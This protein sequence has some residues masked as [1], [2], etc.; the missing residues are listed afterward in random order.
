MNIS[1]NDKISIARGIAW[2]AAIFSI[3]ICV[4]LIAN[5]I[6]YKSV[7]PL[8]SE[9]LNTLV[10]RLHVNPQDEALKEDIRALDLLIRKAYFTSQWQIKTGAYLLIF[11][12]LVFVL[13]VRY[14]NSLKSKL[15][16]LEGIEKNPFLD[17]QL[18]RKW[19]VYVGAGLILLALTSGY[20]SYNALDSYEP[21][22]MANT[23]TVD[24]PIIEE[25]TLVSTEVVQEDPIVSEEEIQEAEKTTTVEKT[26]S[27]DIS[28][29][30]K[31][32]PT[33]AEEQTKV[34]AETK[35]EKKEANQYKTDISIIAN[36]DELNENYPFFRGPQTNG[37]VHQTNIPTN[38]DGASGENILW[39]VKVPKHGYNSPIIWEDKLFLSGADNTVRQVYCFNKN[40]GEIL[41]QVDATGIP[42][43]PANAPETT[44]DT[45]LAA[46]TMATNGENVFAIFGTGDLVSLD[47]NGEKIWAKNLGVPDNHYG[48]SSSLII[49]KDKLVVQYDTNK[50]GKVM[51]FNAVTGEK[52]WET[53]RTGVR[54]SWASPVLAR[55]DDRDELI[56]TAE[57]LVVSYN[58]DTGEKLW[59]VD[60][61]MG[62]VGP[63]VGYADGIVYAANEYATL[64]AIDTK[65]GEIVWEDSDY[66]PEVASPLAAEGLL[67]IATSYGVIACF[68]AKDGTK[69][70]EQEY[71]DGFYGSPILAEGNIFITDM[72]GKTH[73]FKLAKEYQLIADP[74]LGEEST[75]TPA[76][77]DGRIYLRGF[78]HLYC[79]GE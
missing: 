34:V 26:T 61:M 45:G 23:E 31:E 75:C 12:I 9:A 32:S 57:P 62:E 10:E 52:I 14:M 48:H 29:E 46:S 33:N 19:V 21:K 15:D 74:E 7:D 58:P 47:M 67:I 44:E 17:K 16:E 20:F 40:T 8:E 38:W 6:Q 39:K 77:S 2:I 54:I 73:I 13:A 30:T 53:V 64:A 65:T 78:E 43:S 69:Y 68:D 70:W 59:E 36:Q 72:S 56:L 24:Q 60:C 50:G 27:D 51:A 22:V 4:M 1:T 66:L 63:S 28:E 37:I 79:I 42:G 5:Y 41:W 49:Y 11:A 76:F 25:A 55:T 35:L 71:A 18:A 3:I